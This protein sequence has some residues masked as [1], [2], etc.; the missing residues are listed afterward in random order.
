M[1]TWCQE[2]PKSE[3]ALWCLPSLGKFIKTYNLTEDF[4]KT[5]EIVIQPVLNSGSKI[6]SDTNQ[7]MCFLFSHLICAPSGS[8]YIQNQLDDLFITWLRCPGSYG[9]LLKSYPATQQIRYF[10]RVVDLVEMKELDV[11]EDRE[12]LTRFLYWVNTWEPINKF[13]LKERLDYLKKE[14]P[15][16]GLWEIVRLD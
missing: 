8:A 13:K 12:P 3:D 15:A 10:Q 7:S 16:S 14:F 9:K 4:C 6:T 2:F 1:L 5:L 11:D